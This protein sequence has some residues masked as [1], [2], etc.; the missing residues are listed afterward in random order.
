MICNKSMAG[1]S[2]P[3]T[4]DVEIYNF[5]LLNIANSFLGKRL[6]YHISLKRTQ[7]HLKI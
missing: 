7:I 2:T 5:K 3:K 1:Y 4:I 6:N